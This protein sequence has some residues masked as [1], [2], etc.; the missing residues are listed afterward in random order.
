[1]IRWPT[2]REVKDNRYRGLKIGDNL[3]TSII[4]RKGILQID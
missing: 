2:L 3:N 1:M 4:V